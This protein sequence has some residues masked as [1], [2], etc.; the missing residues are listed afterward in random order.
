MV[1]VDGI[2]RVRPGIQVSPGP[3]SPGPP[4]NAKPANSGGDG[5][6]AGH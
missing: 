5:N 4:A 2:Q 6:S 1:V 3:A